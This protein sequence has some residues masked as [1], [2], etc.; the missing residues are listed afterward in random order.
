MMIVLLDSD[1]SLIAQQTM[2]LIAQALSQMCRLRC[3][4][5]TGTETGDNIDIKDNA[6]FT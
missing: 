2:L 3:V 5:V 6:L 4:C 1:G